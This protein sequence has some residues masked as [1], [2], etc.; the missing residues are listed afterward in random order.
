MRAGAHHEPSGPT[1]PWFVL[2]GAALALVFIAAW[3]L[4][5]YFERREKA[6]NGSG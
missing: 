3:A 5:A 1:V 2:A 6:R 4:V